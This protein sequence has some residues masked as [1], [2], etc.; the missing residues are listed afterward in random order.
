MGIHHSA[1]RSAIIFA[2]FLSCLPSPTRKQWDG[3]D[4]Q[5]DLGD[6]SENARDDASIRPI[7]RTDQEVPTGADQGDFL[8][9]PNESPN[10]WD[11][12]LFV[13]VLVPDDSATQGEPMGVQCR[14]GDG[15]CNTKECGETKDSC[16]A[17]CSGCGNGAC[18]PGENPVS[19]P[20]DCCKCGDGICMGFKCDEP[21][22]CPKDCG[23]ACGNK[24]C[25]VGEIP[26][27][28]Q[29]DGCPGMFICPEDCHWKACG[30]GICSPEDVEEGKTCPQDCGTT[31]GN[32]TCDSV[33]NW[34]TCPLDCGFCG[35]G[36][37]VKQQG[38]TSVTCPDDCG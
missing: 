9:S 34:I 8:E 32:Q 22:W 15:D 27:C 18:D 23:T 21:S 29:D 35:D 16:P 3:I 24:V 14:C 4:H 28:V 25:D 10:I 13:D 26:Y 7:L 36:Y 33:E 31:C 38:E 5:R 1:L 6:F 30:D 17:D 20:E 12:E 37:C 2:A 11:A 19:C